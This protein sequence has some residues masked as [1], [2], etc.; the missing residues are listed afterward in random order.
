MSL[1]PLKVITKAQA[2][3][4]HAIA[5]KV[6]DGDLTYEVITIVPNENGLNALWK[7]LGYTDSQP[8]YGKCPTVVVVSSNHFEP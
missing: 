6:H 5:H 8:N 3:S 1:E 2:Y 4:G 7:Q